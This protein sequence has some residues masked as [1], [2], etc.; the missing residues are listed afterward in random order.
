[1]QLS[2]GVG[3]GPRW[4]RVCV[5][6]GGEPDVRGGAGSVRLAG[7]PQTAD[8][9]GPDGIRLRVVRIFVKYKEQSL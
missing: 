5:W 3:K 7:G 4:V 1:V 6:G 2:R 8:R 9:S